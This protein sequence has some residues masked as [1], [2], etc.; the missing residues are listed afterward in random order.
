MI[1]E[2]TLAAMTLS[3][4]NST[5]SGTYLR[6]KTA[7]DDGWYTGYVESVNRGD[8]DK[9]YLLIRKSNGEL[10]YIN[11]KINK[12]KYVLISIR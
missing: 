7:D 4:I 5:Y 10:R 1:R 2:P 11:L 3:D 6:F 8:N 12:L 9:A